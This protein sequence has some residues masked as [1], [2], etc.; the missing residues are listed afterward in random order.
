MSDTT[1]VVRAAQSEPR[2]RRALLADAALGVLQAE[3]GRG[4]THRAVDRRAGLPE[5]STSNYFQTREALL[6]AALRR[7]VDLEQPAV[8]SMEALLPGGPY[9]PRRS[10][11]LVAE[12]IRPWLGGERAGFGMARHELLLEARRRPD[13]KLALDEVHREY[14]LL[15][16]RLLP[17]AGC[18]DPHAHAPQL[19]VILDGLMLQ[20]LFQPATALTEPAIVD[21]LE[22]FFSSC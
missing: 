8:R 18:A 7:L 17:G 15:A 22:R 9:E 4:L 14:L 20:G 21:L 1:A 13:F 5:G 19:L 6:T 2:D 12:H 3:G 16:E 11:E 10:A